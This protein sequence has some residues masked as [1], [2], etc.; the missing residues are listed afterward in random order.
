M[1]TR[2]ILVFLPALATGCKAVDCG[3]GTTER[4]GMCVPSSETVAPAGCGPG[5]MLQGDLCVPRLPPTRCDP[6]TTAPDVDSM[7]VTTCIGTSAGCS[8]KL[9]CPAPTD[10]TQTICGQIY[11][12]ETGEPFATASP[13]GAK[14][15][16]PATSGPCALGIKAFDAVVFAMSNGT[17]GGLATGEVYID[18]CG[19]Y[20]VSNIVMP[21]GPLIAL[22]FDD[23][24]PTKA[25]PM[26]ITNAVGIATGKGV[27]ATK[28]L[29]AFVVAPATT[30]GWV[31]AGVPFDASNG[32]FAAV[33]RGSRTGTE[34]AAGVAI[35][36][37]GSPDGNHDYY[38]AS[39]ATG[40]VTLDA[41]A[42]QTG[43]N[44]TGL[45]NITSPMLTDLYSGIGGLPAGCVW[46]QHPGASVRFV[47]FVQ[48]FR[49]TNAP[50][51]TC[52]L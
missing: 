11:S 19:R 18:D 14:C 47:V 46:D 9:P 35:T 36:R 27:A 49:P 10:G 6:Q 8:T 30:A 12:F 38:F 33:F 1:H 26:G 5:T 22:G 32:I 48:T 2:F 29:D 20:R 51:M 24:D 17:A 16:C 15:A 40:R 39:G 7:G 41:A 3:D 13:S 45:F 37:N 52:S 25:G 21:S 31:G 23:A 50:S 28:D 42:T 44:G 4:N 43:A 34:L